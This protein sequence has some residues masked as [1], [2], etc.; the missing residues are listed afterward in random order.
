MFVAGAIAQGS[1][2]ALANARP[3]E[4]VQILDSLDAENNRL[5]QEKR[6]LAA[7]VESLTSGSD[8][9]ALAQAQNRKESLEVLAGTTKVRGPGV[10]IVIRDEDGGVD[11]AEILDTV[12][13]LR[14]AGAESIEVAERRVV[15][16][17]W[18]ANPPDTGTPAILIS[19]EPAPLARTRS[20]PS[21]IPRPWPPRWRSPAA[22]RTRCAPPVPCSRWSSVTRWRSPRPFR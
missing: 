2:E 13:E 8:A 5:E 19:G 1:D 17:T 15:V 6:R 12:Q 9:A 11:A 18:F 14:D 4:L 22:S 21:V 10:R 7:E 20:W 3:D 16:N